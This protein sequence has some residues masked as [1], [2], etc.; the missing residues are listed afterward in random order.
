MSSITITNEEANTIVES[1]LKKYWFL[2]EP[3]IEVYFDKDDKPYF[4][5]FSYV[6]VKDKLYKKL[7]VVTL[8]QFKEFLLKALIQQGKPIDGV[9]L[10]QG[11]K[12]AISYK[13]HRKR[14]KMR[15]E[16]KNYRAQ[17][18]PVKKAPV[19]FVDSKKKRLRKELK[20]E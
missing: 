20:G 9:S 6:R 10:L 8:E 15:S 2:S 11:K 13:L 16:E 4:H 19:Y 1:Y 18:T 14:E 3:K 17:L 12:K 5:V 7:T